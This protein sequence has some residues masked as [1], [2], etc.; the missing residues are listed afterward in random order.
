MTTNNGKVTLAVLK[1]RMDNLEREFGEVSKDTKL[2][3]E[4]H[5]PHIQTEIA[6]ISTE[7]NSL[8]SWIVGSSVFNIGA[9]VLGIMVVKFLT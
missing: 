9:I 6:S 2:I 5:L 8:K 1:N 3:L 4:N 7:L